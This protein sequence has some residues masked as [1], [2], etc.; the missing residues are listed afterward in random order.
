MK[1]IDRLKKSIRGVDKNKPVTQLMLSEMLRSLWSDQGKIINIIYNEI[2]NN[3]TNIYQSINQ[4]IGANLTKQ[5]TGITLITANWSLVAGLYEYTLA[6]VNITDN[7]I[8]EVIP[9]NASIAIIKAAE[10][11]PETDSSAGSVKLYATNAPT[12]DISVTIN[13]TEKQ[14]S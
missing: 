11:L 10:V 4:I 8:V 14:V 12:G 1:A 3:T 7:S 6:D 5:I 9:A 13:I 2:I